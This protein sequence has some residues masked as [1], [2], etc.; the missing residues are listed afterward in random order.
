MSFEMVIPALAFRT[1]DNRLDLE[2]TRTYAERAAET[3]T[4][5][6]ILSGST[7][8]GDLLT[9]TERAVILDVWSDVMEPSRL[10]ACCWH[11]E[12]MEQAE[13]RNILPVV[14]MQDLSDQAAACSFFAGLPA[15][16]FVYSNPSFTPTPL[17]PALAAAA[18][19]QGIL[20]AGAKISKIA[21][22]DIG[23]MRASVGPQFTLWDGSSRH[24]GAS[25]TAGASGI[26]ATPLAVL[27]APFPQRSIDELQATLHQ[28]YAKVD[29]AASRA[30]RMDLL[31]LLFRQP[32]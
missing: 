5:R 31:T 29:G 13:H 30:D 7:A 15:G 6:F 8:L 20:P 16:A 9:V 3:W 25:L 23:A 26:V 21:V 18:N 14:V 32:V 2:L 1:A 17:H 4:D 27:P 12:D 19:R 10:L 11:R 22:N 28:L 24:I